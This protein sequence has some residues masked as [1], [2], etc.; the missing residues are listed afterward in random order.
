MAKRPITTGINVT[1]PSAPYGSNANNPQEHTVLEDVLNL[2]LKQV[3]ADVQD[4]LVNNNHE[5][6]FFEYGDTVKIVALNPN[7][8]KIE[9][10]DFKN[11]TR[12]MLDD[13]QFSEA[14][15][16]IDKSLAHGFKISDLTKIEER[17]NRESALTALQGQKIRET[18]NFLTLDLILKNTDIPSIGVVSNPL[19]IH[20]AG[21]DPANELFKIVNTIRMQME[22]SGATDR[23]GQYSF[24][25]NPTEQISATASMFIAPELK[26]ELLNSQYLRYDDVAEGVIREGKYEKFGGY[27]LNTANELSTASPVCCQALLDRKN[28][29][30]THNAA[31]E[32]VEKDAAGV[33]LPST[34]E[35][36][37]IVVGTKN[38]VTRA[39]R[40]LPIEK[41]RSEVEFAT[42][43]TCMEIYGEMVA[44]PQAGCIVIVEVP[45]TSII[46]FSGNN[47]EGSGV[48]K[49]STT[50][51][52]QY[53]E[54]LP[55]V[56]VSSPDSDVNTGAPY[57]GIGRDAV[58]G[59][60]AANTG[61]GQYAIEADSDSDSDTDVDTDTD[62]DTD[63]DDN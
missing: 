47:F 43:Y 25:A 48:D 35:L 4:Q 7:S 44:V 37:A 41:M 34:S 28:Y 32:V 11:I 56:K 3:N 10:R 45:A 39:S 46:T 26:L 57:A 59:G 17:W 2:Q 33:L 53:K 55:Y 20:G 9:A 51:K 23:N 16:L 62:A 14:T 63:T 5:K 21:I 49:D 19:S 42:K 12:P 24:G 52:L 29:L 8:V 50:L 40:T 60:F 6:K 13:V 61:Y 18:H 31:G 15:M 36:A 22:R 1:N 30:Q 58:E 27:I 54:E 38:L